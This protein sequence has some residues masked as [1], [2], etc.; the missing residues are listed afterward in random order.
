[1]ATVATDDKIGLEAAVVSAR[2]AIVQRRGGAVE[3]GGRDGF[4]IED[5]RHVRAKHRG[6]EIFDDLLLAVHGHMLPACKVV[7][8][9]TVTA[10]TK[11]QRDAAMD[12]PFSPQSLAH[13][14]CVQELDAAV[15]EHAGADPA[16]DVFSRARLDDGRIDAGPLE[17]NRQRE[18]GWPGADY[19]GTRSQCAAPLGYRKV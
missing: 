8:I 16:L 2:V 5:D 15:L 7:E 1:M 12:E 11:T 10:A 13:S 3:F 9:D 14:D 17:Q 18:A 19:R 4:G 6:D